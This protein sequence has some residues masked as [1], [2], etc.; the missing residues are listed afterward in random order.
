MQSPP[1]LRYVVL[2]VDHSCRPGNENTFMLLTDRSVSSNPLVWHPG[3]P[4]PHGQP[5]LCDAHTVHW[6]Y[7]QFGLSTKTVQRLSATGHPGQPS[8]VPHFRGQSAGSQ[9][10]SC[11]QCRSRQPVAQAPLVLCGLRSALCLRQRPAVR[12]PTARY[13]KGNRT[14]MAPTPQPFR[15]SSRST[16]YLTVQAAPRSQAPTLQSSLLTQGLAPCLCLAP[17]HT[18]DPSPSTGGRASSTMS[19]PSG[20]QLHP[21]QPATTRPCLWARNT[22]A[23]AAGGDRTPS[24]CL[25][26]S[27][28]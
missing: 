19:A 20:V 16:T 12:L 23:A 10:I 6:A 21:R 17:D 5:Q 14:H 28:L 1:S 18:V 9:C 3:Q 27:A 15:R 4:N 26:N 8:H 7:L 22:D 2:F 24:R 25:G 11:P 13:A